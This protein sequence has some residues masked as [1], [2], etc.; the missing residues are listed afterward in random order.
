M[1]SY[2]DP[3]R[4]LHFKILKI[5]LNENYVIAPL[6]LVQTPLFSTLS[7]KLTVFLPLVQ[8]VQIQKCDFREQ[9]QGEKKI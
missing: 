9:E 7:R 8:G 1:V 4:K 5:L 3:N 2:F 6:F